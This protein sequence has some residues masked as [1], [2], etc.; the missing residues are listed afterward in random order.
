MHAGMCRQ[1]LSYKPPVNAFDVVG[2]HKSQAAAVLHGRAEIDGHH[3]IL[4]TGLDLVHDDGK[5]SVC[6]VGFLPEADLDAT[7]VIDFS[8]HLENTFEIVVPSGTSGFA[9]QGIRAFL[10]E[11]TVRE[12]RRSCRG[13]TRIGL[14]PGKVFQVRGTP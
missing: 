4:V 7:E 3:R 12:R 5:C 2:V 8:F 14:A 10:T 13:R 1:T 11:R 9:W 6:P